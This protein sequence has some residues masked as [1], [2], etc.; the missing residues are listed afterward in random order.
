MQLRLAGIEPAA[1]V[2]EI[3][4][5]DAL[6]RR[7]ACE[8]FAAEVKSV[9]C[10]LLLDGFARRAVSFEP[11]KALLVDYVKVDGSITRNVLRAASAVTKLKAILRVGQV[12]GM[13]IIAECVEDETTLAGLKELGVGHV[14]GFG[15]QR[16]APLEDLFAA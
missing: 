14:Q 5:D 16:P 2:L 7:A 8:R 9:G 15:V 11:L 10:R 1:L 4:E 6:D 3:S 12:T 13:G